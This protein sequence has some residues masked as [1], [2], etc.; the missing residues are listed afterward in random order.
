MTHV[1]II[2]FEN[3]LLKISSRLSDR[4][5]AD[6]E[7]IKSNRS[8]LFHLKSQLELFL[9]LTFFFKSLAGEEMSLYLEFNTQVL[10]D[11]T[12]VT[13][14]YFSTIN[15]LLI[16]SL[17]PSRWWI[18]VSVY[19]SLFLVR[20]Y[21]I[22]HMKAYYRNNQIHFSYSFCWIIKSSFFFFC[23]KMTF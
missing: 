7:K 10:M 9:F 21:F 16:P 18:F 19:S 20:L 5:K 4:H 3:I 15:G 1:I 12:K 23:R 13:Y 8:W 14:L 2:H 11:L 17:F 22:I 6:L